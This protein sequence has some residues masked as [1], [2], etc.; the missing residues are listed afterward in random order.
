MRSIKSKAIKT[1]RIS[2]NCFG[3][4]FILSGQS[5]GRAECNHTVIL[6][7]S[8]MK[9]KAIKTVRISI[10][11]FGF[12]LILSEQSQG[13]PEWNHTSFIGK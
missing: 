11:C 2:I 6:E 4:H 12:H 5:Q 7:Y 13:R 8:N 9:E 10:N 1:V 3:F